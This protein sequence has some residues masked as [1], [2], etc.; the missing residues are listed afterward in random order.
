MGLLFTMW[1]TKPRMT[2]QK[3]SRLI[4]GPEKVTRPRTQQ[5][6]IIIIVIIILDHLY[7]GYLQLYN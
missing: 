1:E 3:T 2:P 6:I 7:A 4:M 5:I